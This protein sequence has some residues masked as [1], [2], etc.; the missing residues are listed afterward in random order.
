[1]RQLPGLDRLQGDGQAGHVAERPFI[2]AISQG[3][4]EGVH[5]GAVTV[6]VFRRGAGVESFGVKMAFVFHL[7][8]F[9]FAKFCLHMSK[10]RWTA[11]EYNWLNA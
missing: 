10:L 5:Q 7:I 4:G 8:G 6:A 9:W 11:P 2:L 3:I 1:M